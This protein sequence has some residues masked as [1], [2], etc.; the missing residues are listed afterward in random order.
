MA[1]GISNAGVKTAL[2]V[3]MK[4]KNHGN[5]GDRK[6]KISLIALTVLSSAMVRAA[7][8]EPATMRAWEE[9]V[10]ITTA[11]MERRLEPGQPFLWAEESPDRLAKLKAGEIIVSPAAAHNPKRVPSGLI[12]DWIGAA[13]MPNV[14]LNDV[15]RMLRDYGRYKDVYQPAVV[16]SKLIATVED[17]DSFSMVLMNKAFFVKSALDTDYESNFIHL[18]EHRVYSISRTTRVQQIDDYGSPS[19]HMLNEGKGSGFLWQLF[20][21]TRFMERDGGVY[22]EVEAAGL[23]RDIPAAMRWFVDPIVRN[24]SR[25]SLKTSLLETERGVRSQTVELTKASGGF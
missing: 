7:S 1:L 12:H 19:Q 14:K 16:D 17:Q 22:I 25:D 18:D 13:F 2:S 5:G 10:K 6:K 23:S 20:S 11:Q 9:H 21:I 8:L 15:L 3:G 4:T 24:V